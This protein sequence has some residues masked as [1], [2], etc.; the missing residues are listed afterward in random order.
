MIC[1]GLFGLITAKIIIHES[2]GFFDSVTIFEKEA[3][4]GG[5]WRA[6]QIYPGLA[7]NSPARTY[8]IPGFK[9]PE[10]QRKTG[11]HVSAESIN[12][13]LKSF[14]RT[15]GLEHH[16]SFETLVSSIFWDRKTSLW[17]LSL[18]QGPKTFNKSF[19]FLVICNGMY[20]EPNLPGIVSISD[21]FTGK[22]F[23]SRNVGAHSVREQLSGSLHNL[24]VGAGKSAL[25]L[26]T[27]LARQAW[28]ESK[29]KCPHVTL[30]Y[31]KPHWLSPRVIIRSS[32][33]FERVMFSRFV[34][35]WLPFSEHPDRFHR[36]SAQS[37]LGKICTHAIFA[38]IEDD[39]IKGCG[40]QDLPLTVPDYPIKQA[41]SG[42]LH[43]EPLGYLNLVRDGK[44]TIL[45][46][47]LRSMKG[48]TV[49]IRTRSNEQKQLKV[50]SIVW[51]TGYT[52]GPFRNIAFNGFA[53]SLLNPTVAYVSAHWIADYFS[54]NLYIPSSSVVQKGKLKNWTTLPP[55]ALTTIRYRSILC[56]AEKYF[57]CPWSKRYTHWLTCHTIRR[58]TYS[59]HGASHRTCS[60]IKVQSYTLCKRMVQANVSTDIFYATCGEN[61][62]KF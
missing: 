38:L 37:S 22:M 7:S 17:T 5:V 39:F 19:K 25:D 10:A 32:V 54:G 18:Q 3:E 27:A 48:S 58:S 44:I 45:Q 30:L 29:S 41:L 34:N 26:A 40:Q 14:S 21:S 1:I 8:E 42:A 49:T 55:R 11:S 20:H 51:A 53:Y 9:Y 56:L 59:G 4:I 2:A 6:G 36:W 50:D 60:W 12:A 43:V 57:W 13:Y 24:V 31:R 23:H 35:A 47:E 62:S 33:F 16:I 52:L 15:Y 61:G 28:A 46:G